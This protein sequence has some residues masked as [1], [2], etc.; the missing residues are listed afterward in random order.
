MTSDP[1]IARISNAV[2]C[3]CLLI[4]LIKCH[5]SLGSFFEGVLNVFVI[6]IA[7]AFVITLIKCPKGHKSLG[8]LSG[9][10]FQRWQ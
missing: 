6:V 7:I 1:N 2:P 5:K 10:V 8:S 9:S 4:T 3:R